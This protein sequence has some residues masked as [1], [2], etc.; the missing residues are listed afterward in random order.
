MDYDDSM[1]TI[2]LPF[3]LPVIDV[4]SIEIPNI[5]L[6]KVDTSRLQSFA[7]DAFYV[8]VGLGVLAVQQM[9]VRRQ[10]LIKRFSTLE[11]QFQAQA[12]T[13]ESRFSDV[14]AKL[15]QVME[16]LKSRL[17]EPADKLLDKA[18]G[19]AKTTR[20]QVVELLTKAA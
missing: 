3:N 20:K 15:D 16:Q 13:V 18:Y 7:T 8:T 2:K 12:G 19:T 9:Q 6:A 1:T 4:P 14:E 10:E 5:D 11:S 17:P